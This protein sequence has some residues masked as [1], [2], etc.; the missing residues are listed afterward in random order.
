MQ[1]HQEKN[2]HHLSPLREVEVIQKMS[3]H[4][5]LARLYF[6]ILQMMAEWMRRDVI[7]VVDWSVAT[8]EQVTFNFLTIKKAGL[9]IENENFSNL[10][11]KCFPY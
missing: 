7:L 10:T 5:F 3:F 6:E 9:L 4:Q 11:R 8:C 1:G 2:L